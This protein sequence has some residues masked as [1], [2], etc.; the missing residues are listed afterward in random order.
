M[1]TR[2]FIMRKVS[3][4]AVAI[5]LF[6]CEKTET[7]ESHWENKA[8]Y[9][10][11]LESQIYDHEHMAIDPLP[12]SLQNLRISKKSEEIKTYRDSTWAL[13]K[14]AMA[15]E[16]A[17]LGLTSI[18][19]NNAEAVWKIPQEQQMKIRFLTKGEAPAEG[20][21]LFIN[22]HGGGKDPSVMGPWG[23]LMNEGEWQAAITLGGRYDD[24]PSL[25]IVPRMADDRIGRW[26]LQPQRVAFERAIRAALASEVVN[27]HR[28]Y[29]L[30]ISEGGYGSHRLAMFFPDQFTAFGP[31]AAAEPMGDYAMNLR[32]TNI[33]IEVGEHDSGFGRNKMAQEW[34]D[35]LSELHQKSPDLF[36]HVVVIQ[37][38]KGHGIDYTQVS[39]W[40]AQQAHRATYPAHI[41]YQFH[42][43][44]GFVPKLYYLDFSGLTFPDQE[45]RPV[46]EVKHDGNQFDIQLTGE[47]Q[48]TGT[49]RLYLHEDQVDLGKSI[50]VTFKGEKIFDQKV[51][52]TL[53]SLLQS[54]VCFGDPLRIFP[55][56][57]EL[58]I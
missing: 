24:A 14:E 17:R 12:E 42:H 25:Y 54:M 58:K 11:Y 44:E 57:I 20:Y 1:S 46:L 34:K 40:L 32:N 55:A 53:G 28:L 38:G 26:Y 35:K 8:D 9:L 29:L 27:P 39:P 13:W 23:S 10:S 36:N 45:A 52:P 31:M 30:G 21:P 2:K 41:T 3:L 15:K 56:Y 4:L 49:L 43:L 51:T 16:T 18:P 5:I 37:P 7:I 6:A 47:G 33:R 50:T 19:E 22:L 48:P